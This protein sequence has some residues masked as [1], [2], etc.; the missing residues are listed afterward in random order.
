MANL[1]ALLLYLWAIF[2]QEPFDPAVALVVGVRD[3]VA[4]CWVGG[5]Q[6]VRVLWRPPRHWQTSVSIS[7]VLADSC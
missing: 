1:W 3:G 7:M 2:T 5:F 4:G 6:G